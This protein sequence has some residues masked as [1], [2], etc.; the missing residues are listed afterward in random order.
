MAQ[1][2][3]VAM[4]TGCILSLEAT[5]STPLPVTSQKAERIRAAAR[6]LDD[7]VTDIA[8][9][10]FI[11]TEPM[12]RSGLERLRDYYPPRNVPVRTR[13][14]NPARRQF[15]WAIARAFYKH[16]HEFH[17]QAITEIVALLW[18]ATD[19]R[20]VRHELT[21]ERKAE[22][23]KAAEAENIASGRAAVEATALLS[24]AQ[25]KPAPSPEGALTSSPSDS[26]RLRDTL[27]MLQSLEDT[28]LA[29]SLVQGIQNILAEFD[30]ELRDS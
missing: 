25:R 11:T 7:E 3:Y 1:Q 18:P 10:N 21:S 19:E 23:A 27:T 22:I 26:Q 14:G 13:K 15:I 8:S 28:E 2:I 12:F 4:V 6:K 30:F 24:R 16:F 17:I 9:L 20:N 5:A 29:S